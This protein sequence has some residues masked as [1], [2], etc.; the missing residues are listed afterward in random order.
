[1]LYEK[2]LGPLA[3]WGIWFRSIPDEPVVPR[4]LTSLDV[5]LLSCHA[6]LHT[7]VKGWQDRFSFGNKTVVTA[8]SSIQQR[9]NDIKM[10]Q[11]AKAGL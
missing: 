7:S 8:V 5:P 11:S 9:S 6:L 10:G 4:V 1:M 2:F 3:G